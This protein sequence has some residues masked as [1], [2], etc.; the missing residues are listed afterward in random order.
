VTT[1]SLFWYDLETTGRD[2][3]RDRIL[4]FAGQRTD[5]SLRPVGNPI[6]LLCKPPR[7]ALPDPEAIALT[8]ISFDQCES[9]G[10][11]EYEFAHRI[12]EA[13]E[14]PG[15][16]VLGFNS[17]RFDDEFLRNLFYRNLLD[18]YAREW[19]NDRSRWDLIDVVRLCRALRPRGIEWPTDDTGKAVN[20][21]EQ[22]TQANGL[23]HASA[24]DALSDVNATIAVANL[25]KT[26]QPRLFDF[27]FSHRDKRSA[28][29]LLDLHNPTPLLHVSGMY[30]ADRSF[31]AVVLP[32]A[33]HPTNR[34]GI[35]VADLQYDGKPFAAL[36][37]EALRERWFGDKESL[38]DV[39]RLPVKTV[40]TNRC[41]V[42]APLSVLAEGDAERLGIDTDAAL[43][44][45][46]AWQNTSLT[47]SLEAI[48]SDPQFDSPTDPE[49]QLY[50]GGF[51]SP[52]DRGL[53]NEVARTPPSQ[54][55][56]FD[57][58]RFEDNRLPTLLFRLRARNWPGTLTES[59]QQTW[60]TWLDGALDDGNLRRTDTQSFRESITRIRGERP[61][62]AQLMTELEQWY[63]R[64]FSSR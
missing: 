5:L 39:P 58:S 35:L 23:T 24:H 12:L 32:I 19:Q 15:T 43:A 34:N 62:T 29:Q 42:L 17:L 49:L 9:E 48:L 33:G 57:A 1:D 40:H 61:H 8:G 10:L 50:S 44:H 27:A 20:R 11:D 21:L 13:L 31:V 16:C 56:S 59:E 26:R 53:M 55:R 2:P 63:T 37:T 22:L 25:I 38:G 51:F 6:N 52:R 7:D 18:P 60:N 64:A 28:A 41:P 36:S 30:G 45:A 3:A 14:P 46:T 54:L 47:R 4:Q